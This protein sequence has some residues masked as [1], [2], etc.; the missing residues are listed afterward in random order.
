MKAVCGNNYGKLRVHNMYGKPHTYTE[1]VNEMKSQ[2]TQ[3]YLTNTT[4]VK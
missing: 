4:Y 2:H 3:I 1:N